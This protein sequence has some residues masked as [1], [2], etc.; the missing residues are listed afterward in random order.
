MI[1]IDC[2]PDLS[3]AEVKRLL[4]DR[5]NSGAYPTVDRLL[6]GL[7][8]KPISYAL[9]KEAGLSPLDAPV[10]PKL[11]AAVDRLAHLVKEW[12]FTVTGDIGFE[13]AQVAL[14]GI[15]LDA[16]D[17]DLQSKSYPCLYFVGEGVDVTG[18][19]G[20]YNLHWAWLSGLIA[21]ER[22]AS[23]RK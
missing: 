5:V 9:L 20:G 3:L 23:V 14:G 11:S 22:A 15:R 13:S 1:T 19:C 8:A 2:L 17:A 7:V 12:P 10:T 21:G 16:L 4:M 6:L 18:L